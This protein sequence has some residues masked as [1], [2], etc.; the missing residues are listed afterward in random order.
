M[1]ALREANDSL[2]AEIESQAAE[3]ESLTRQNHL[4]TERVNKQLHINAELQRENHVMGERIQQ[5]KVE[6]LNERARNGA[7]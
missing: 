2:I 6:V 3:I 4:L 7:D 5:L 1:S